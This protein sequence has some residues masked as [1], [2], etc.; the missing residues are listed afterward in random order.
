MASKVIHPASSAP[1]SADSERITLPISGMT[2]AACQSF[3]ERTLAGQPGVT[4]A[5]VNLML[6]NATVTYDPAATS[7]GALVEA[8]RKTGYGAE[9]PS[10]GQSALAEQD[11]EERRQ[12]QEH[13]DLRRKSTVSIV[14]GAVAMLAS[15]P[16]MSA[17]AVAGLHHVQDPL[18]AW[19]MRVLDPALR[20]ALP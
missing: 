18:L 6:H 17:G 11:A 7:P 14:V 5:S 3:V 9:L 12:Q 20:T 8:V 15:M 16:L 1:P 13:A 2:C 19:S 10:P 4:G